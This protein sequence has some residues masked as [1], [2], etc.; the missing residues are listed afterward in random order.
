MSTFGFSSTTDDVLAG[1]DLTGRLAVVTGA[2]TGLGEETTACPR[3]PRRRGRH[4]G[5]RRRARRDGG[6]ARPRSRRP[7]RPA[8]GARARSRLTR[9]R[10]RLRRP[11]PRRARP[12]R[13][14]HQQRGPDGLPARDD[15]GRLRAAVRHEPPRALPPRHVAH[16]GARRRGSVPTRVADVAGTRRVRRRP[17]GLRVRAHAL[18]RV[19]RL[20][21]IEDRQRPVRR[22]LRSPSRRPAAS[23]PTPCT[24]AASTPS[25][26]A[27]SR[28]R[29]SVRC[30][31]A[32]SRTAV[33]SSGRR[34]RRARRRRCG[35]RQ[36][37][38]S[39]APAATTSR[40]AVSPR[41]PTRPCWKR[42]CVRMP[43]TLSRADALWELSERLVAR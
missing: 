39:T 1:V 26:R 2:S 22:R 14:P 29:P 35:R 38:S 24:R 23:T 37:P 18:R 30:A 40:T 31:V 28:T 36:P 6:R 8:R 12:A 42:A 21:A 3:R 10:A 15:Q 34:S 16:A 17:R 5:P 7:P 27:T 41:S 43:R 20:R 13:P 11:L 19:G 9:Q 33:S 4:G 32:W 25:W